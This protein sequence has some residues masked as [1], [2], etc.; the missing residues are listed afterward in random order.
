MSFTAR[1]KMQSQSASQTSDIVDNL[2]SKPGGKSANALKSTLTSKVGMDPN[3]ILSHCIKMKANLESLDNWIKIT[4]LKLT[5]IAYA[6]TS[7]RD[8]VNGL[9]TYEFNNL[10]SFNYLLR[11]RE[12]SQVSVQQL[13]ELQQKLSTCN[14]HSIDYHVASQQLMF[15]TSELYENIQPRIDETFELASKIQSKP[16]L[17]TTNEKNQNFLFAAGESRSRDALLRLR[18]SMS[19]NENLIATIANN[20]EHTKL[21]IDTI[22]DS[23]QNAKADIDKGRKGTIENVAELKTSRKRS[24]YCYAILIFFIIGL[25]YFILNTILSL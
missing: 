11:L 1:S 10:Q 17:A 7:N 12:L 14:E 2:S 16:V 24:L 22:Y 25:A 19:E 13:E 18:Q 15:F 6:M 20:V 9:S 23:I 8:N 21:T 4:Q 3:Q 5:T